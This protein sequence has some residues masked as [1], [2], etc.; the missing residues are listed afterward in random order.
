MTLDIP[1]DCPGCKKPALVF[2]EG[3]PLC[4]EHYVENLN[5]VNRLGLTPRGLTEDKSVSDEAP[6]ERRVREPVDSPKR[7]APKEEKS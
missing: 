7:P 5:E 6:M 2:L 3:R 4:A 1:C